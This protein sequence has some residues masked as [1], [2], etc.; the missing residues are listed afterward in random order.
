L[1]K[2]FIFLILNFL[3]FN[4]YAETIATIKLSYLIE[5]SIQY[6]SFLKK[7]ESEKNVFHNALRKEEKFLEDRKI[8]IE[9]SKILFNEEELKNQIAIYNEDIKSYQEKINKYNNFLNDNMEINQKKLIDEIFL[10]VKDISIENNIDLVFNEDQY[11]ISNENIDISELVLIKLNNK[12]F[13]LNI[14][15]YK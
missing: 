15:H 14:I 6:I 13:D 11:F 8:K 2:F 12:K 4:I 7:L 3:S 10:I 5:N 9:D 1:N